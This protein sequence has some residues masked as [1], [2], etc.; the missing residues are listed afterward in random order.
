LTVRGLGATALRERLAGDPPAGYSA[1]LL[2]EGDASR[3]TRVRLRP[4][5]PASARSEPSHAP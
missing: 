3:E 2:P 5:A 1:E 4:E